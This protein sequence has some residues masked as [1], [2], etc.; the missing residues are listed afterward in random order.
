MSWINMQELRAMMPCCLDETRRLKRHRYQLQAKVQE[1]LYY[2]TLG[3][4]SYQAKSGRI[5][6]ILSDKAEPNGQL[7]QAN[8][9]ASKA[10]VIKLPRR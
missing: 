3:G 10:G 6:N 1:K 7:G 4:K 5:V 9:S 2:V 8:Y